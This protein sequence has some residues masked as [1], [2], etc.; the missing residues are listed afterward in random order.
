M[1]DIFTKNLP[2]HRTLA[3][4]ITPSDLSE[5]ERHL[6][7]EGDLGYCEGHRVIYRKSAL[8]SC[9]APLVIEGVKESDCKEWGGRDA[10]C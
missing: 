4:R 6:I 7:L 1:A 3:G 10:A 9:V 8:P 5:Q 2:D